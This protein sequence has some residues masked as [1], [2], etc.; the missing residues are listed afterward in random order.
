MRF[1]CRSGYLRFRLNIFLVAAQC[2][3]DPIVGVS[4]RELSEIVRIT[5]NDY[6][7]QHRLEPFGSGPHLRQHG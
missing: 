1:C 6:Q 2:L 4:P 3:H 5:D 7:M